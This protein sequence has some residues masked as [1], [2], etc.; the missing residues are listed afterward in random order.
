[1]NYFH[2]Y[3]HIKDTFSKTSS[4]ETVENID[5]AKPETV[6]EKITKKDEKR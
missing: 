4:R 5:I 2:C 3:I 6:R 1:M